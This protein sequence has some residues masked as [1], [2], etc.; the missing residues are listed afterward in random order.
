[1]KLIRILIILLVFNTLILAGYLTSQMTGNGISERISIN[2]SRVI[3]GDTLDSSVGKIR[4]IGVN[5]PEKNNLGYEEAKQYLQ[6]Y[7]GK[8][9]EL[10]D[11][12]KDKYS[13]TLGYVFYNNQLVNQQ[14]LE[15]GLA[16]LYYYDK[17]EYY[18][19]MKKAEQEARDAGLGIWKK[20]NNAGCVELINL[21]W[22]EVTR[23]NNQEQIILDNNCGKLDITIKDDATHIY[24]L[25]LNSGIYMQNFSCIWNDDGD[26][27]Y[28]YDD[29][30]LMLFY[31]Y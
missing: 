27:L 18:L 20:S 6:G 15:R 26:S 30:G 29:S 9:L 13:R 24:N 8:T 5:T 23:C 11:K 19:D 31:R 28:I 12:G 14:I 16:S 22:K 1:M 2:V 21:G 3:D 7:E 25:E 10:E 4:L 17:D